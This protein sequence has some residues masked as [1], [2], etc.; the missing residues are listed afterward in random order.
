MRLSRIGP[1]VLAL[2]GLEGLAAGLAPS[3]VEGE[4]ITLTTYYPSPRGVYRELTPSEP[5]RDAGVPALR[6]R[7]GGTAGCLTTA[8]TPSAASP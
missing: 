7:S 8:S 1:G 6:C 2:L 5:R 4:E 3:I